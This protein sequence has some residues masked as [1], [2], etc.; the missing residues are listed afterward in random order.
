MIGVPP[1]AICSIN[2]TPVGEP[3]V[4]TSRRIGAALWAEGE[5]ASPHG[6]GKPHRFGVVTGSVWDRETADARYRNAN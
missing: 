2:V 1:D 4:K 5:C 3:C 6:G